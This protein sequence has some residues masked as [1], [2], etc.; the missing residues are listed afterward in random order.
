MH[1]TREMKHR[2]FTTMLVLFAGIDLLS[3]C[4]TGDDNNPGVAERIGGFT[5]PYLFGGGDSPQPCA[6]S[7]TTDAEI[8]WS[9]GS[10]FTTEFEMTVLSNRDM[11]AA[12][13]W[14]IN[15]HD[16]VRPDHR[17]PVQR[18]REGRERTQEGI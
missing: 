9:T 6:T 1:K 15:G 13:L 5:K 18:L 11:P 4:M 2:V 7:S 10:I 8:R 3:K 16:A 17:A 12:C 14:H